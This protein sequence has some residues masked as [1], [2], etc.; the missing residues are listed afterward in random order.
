MTDTATRTTTP[1]SKA[2]VLIAVMLFITMVINYVDRANLSIAMPA[3]S[4]E[5]DLTKAQQGLLLSAFGWT[6][7]A[8]QLPGG[9]LVDKIRPRILYP[10]CLALWS[11]ATLFLGMAG[12]FVMLIVLRLA[13][14]AFEAPAYPI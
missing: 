12:A 13:V 4:G 10:A 8:L 9:F 5:M 1:A 7:A 14:G 2:R 3:I 6:Y 11:L